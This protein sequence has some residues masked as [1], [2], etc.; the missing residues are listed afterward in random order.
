ME[1]DTLTIKEYKFTPK[2]KK[3]LTELEESLG[4][5]TV[6]CEA[7]KTN[8][9]LFYQWKKEIPAFSEAVEAIQEVALDF[10]ESKL[11]ERVHEK[12]DTMIIFYLKTKGKK[13]GYVE[14]IEQTGA[15]GGA[16][17]NET[18]VSFA[19]P[20]IAAKYQDFADEFKK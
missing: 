6:A 18:E 3:V 13:R 16:I 19:D 15:D 9:R 4:V 1:T 8:R 20:E 14:R 11:F 7:A 2:Q 17:K 5:V 10:V 12:S